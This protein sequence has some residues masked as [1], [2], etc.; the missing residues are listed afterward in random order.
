ME[1]VYYKLC[2]LGDTGVGKSSIVHRY[3]FKS[4]DPDSSST[5]GA[6]YH[7]K[8]VI[9]NN[10]CIRLQIWDTAGQERYRSL[11]PMYYRNA[12][13]VLIV[14][15]GTNA[16]GL[17][18]CTQWINQ[19]KQDLPGC[20]LLLVINKSDLEQ[21]IDPTNI[22]DICNF[23]KMDHIFVSAKETINIDK[24]SDKVL[25]IVC[26]EPGEKLQSNIYRL[27]VETPREQF[28]NTWCSII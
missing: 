26:K 6:A 22:T 5:I 23:Y 17:Q 19:V 14:V 18:D 11:A 4:F 25:E 13:L 27:K 15:D 16:D 2:L 21:K 3:I 24:L 28:W 1:K 10:E 9:Y 12:S 20:S 7:S 8:D